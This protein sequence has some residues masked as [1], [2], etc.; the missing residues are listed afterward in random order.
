MAMTPNSTSPARR[1]DFVSRWHR[2]RTSL[3]GREWTR[4]AA[5]FVFILVVN[6]A[7]WGIYVLAV[8][9]HHFNY[10]GVGGSRGLGVGLVSR[11]PPGSSA[12]GT[13]SMPI[14]SPAS[15]TPPAS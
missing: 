14:T 8:M 10:R 12:S 3:T 5:M 15:T 1:D 11:S 7:G 2:I 9:P 13:P 6:A 4:L